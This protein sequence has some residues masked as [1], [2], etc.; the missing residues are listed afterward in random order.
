MNLS[1][2]YLDQ[3]FQVCILI[4]GLI[5]ILKYFPGKKVDNMRNIYELENKRRANLKLRGS[6]N[7]LHYLAPYLLL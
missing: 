2:L 1:D 4:I 3:F 7:E 6:I 5:I